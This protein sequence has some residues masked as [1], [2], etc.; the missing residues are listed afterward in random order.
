[1]EDAPLMRE[2]NSAHHLASILRVFLEH[3]MVC[4]FIA[5][6][7]WMLLSCCLKVR[8]QKPKSGPESVKVLVYRIPSGGGAPYPLRLPTTRETSCWNLQ[9]PHTHPGRLQILKP[10]QTGCFHT[11]IGQSPS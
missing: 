9:L 3:V 11:G 7:L 2:L 4:L 5:F 8:K 1:M 10:W 6:P